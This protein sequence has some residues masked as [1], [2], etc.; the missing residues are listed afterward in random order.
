MDPA[1]LACPKFTNVRKMLMLDQILAL[2]PSLYAN[3]ESD[4]E[5]GGGSETVRWVHKSAS[6]IPVGQH[7]LWV[8]KGSSTQLCCHRWA[9][10]AKWTLRERCR[11]EP[12][13]AQVPQIARRPL[14]DPPNQTPPT[15]ALTCKGFMVPV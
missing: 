13:H 2:P 15:S 9:S 12:Q 10:A 11:R 7:P 5:E 4:G 1:G 6:V 14:R 3:D 8:R